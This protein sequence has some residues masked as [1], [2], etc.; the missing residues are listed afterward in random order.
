MEFFKKI[1]KSAKIFMSKHNVKPQEIWISK[2][3][4]EALKRVEFPSYPSNELIGLKV[5]IDESLHPIK[6]RLIHKTNNK[7]THE[8]YS[9]GII[10]YKK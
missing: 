8:I 7:V 6:F 1:K 9:G 2:S 4:F 3:I 10:D 5:Y